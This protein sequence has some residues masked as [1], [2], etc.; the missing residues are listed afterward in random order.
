MRCI[1]RDIGHLCHDEPREPARRPKGEHS[2]TTGD[3]EMS[4]KREDTSAARMPL[5]IDQLQDIGL[6][7]NS[8]RSTAQQT[9]A[10]NPLST[11]QW[12]PSCEEQTKS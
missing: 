9:S 3:D 7:I 2:H 10:S 5:P 11:G 1:K 12:L 8:A 6:N 4:S